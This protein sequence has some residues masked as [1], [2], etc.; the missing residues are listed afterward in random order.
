VNLGLQTRKLS[1]RKKRLRDDKKG[2][3]KPLNLKVTLPAE[4]LAL[5][6]LARQIG[7]LKRDR[8]DNASKDSQKEMMCS[9]QAAFSP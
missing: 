5:P 2:A 9:L 6:P 7:E 3:I 4:L 1:C 8:S